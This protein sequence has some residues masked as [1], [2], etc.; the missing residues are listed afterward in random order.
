M[1]LGAPL[2]HLSAAASGSG[3]RSVVSFDDFLRAEMT[4]M[5]ANMYRDMNVA[6]P[7]TLDQL[8]IANP[9]LVRQIREQAEG[10]ASEKYRQSL[11]EQQ[12]SQQSHMGG[13]KRTLSAVGLDGG[14]GSGSSSSGSS[15]SHASKKPSIAPTLIA[16]GLPDDDDP[17]AGLAHGTLSVSSAAAP[18]AAPKGEL[19]NGFMC[20]TG[21]VIDVQ[22][23]KTLKAAL[24][25]AA[26][27]DGCGA[28]S[29]G[30]TE[31]E[32]AGYQVA[33]QTT[34]KRLDILLDTV[35]QKPRLPPVLMG[36]LPTTPFEG[37]TS[38]ELYPFCNNVFDIIYNYV[39]LFELRVA[40]LRAPVTCFNA[41]RAGFFWRPWSGCR[42]DRRRAGQRASGTQAARA[43]LPRGRAGAQPGARRTRALRGRPVS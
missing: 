38:F 30:K 20:E 2:H 28:E 25:A 39:E 29:V 8:A 27:G 7:M 13:V 31:G 32:G 14:G 33:A 11:L 34:A 40:A 42:R 19:V 5:V 21:V 36:K 43:R 23:V 26:N 3:G 35:Y 22:R 6:N 1:I 9:Q 18:A 17:A 41:P 10:F 15:D 12:A 4:Q 24:H 37:E 16:S